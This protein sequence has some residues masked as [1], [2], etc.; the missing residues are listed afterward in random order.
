MSY[1]TIDIT[2]VGPAEF[3][4]IAVLRDTIFGEFKH[5]FAGSFAE[6]IEGQRDVLAL[7]AH[8]EGNPVA[9]KV[10][11]QDRPRRYHSWTGGVLRDYRG[12]GIAKRL[13]AWQHGWLRARGYESVSFNSFNKFRPMLQFGLSS[14]FVP[15]G[16]TLR[17]ENELS[18]GFVKDL[19][20]AD[21]PPRERVAPAA[22]HVESVSPNFHGLIARL[23]TELGD[24]R[25]EAEVDREMTGADPLALVAFVEDR[26]VGFVIGRGVG[27]EPGVYAS[28]LGGVLPAW[29]DRG[30]GEAL[31]AQLSKAA[32][33]VGY[34][35]LRCRAP[36][37]DAP[38]IR[39][40]L[41][42]GFDFNGMTFDGG[43]KAM[44]VVLERA[45]GAAS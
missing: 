3:P 17:Q 23:A 7:I 22:V 25:S 1:T 41:N 34:R 27:D 45:L 35:V 4:L 6:Q 5:R 14:G 2:E 36:H 39:A 15:T 19:T 37:D 42:L 40:C 33:G 9:Y 32:G 21:P 18:I 26:P 29:R 24:V 31:L 12:Q 16:V 44:T 43:R 11:H 10:G 28:R 13:Q 20:K 38:L 30:V 8:L